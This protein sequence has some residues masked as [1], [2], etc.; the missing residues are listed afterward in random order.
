MR[1]FKISFLPCVCRHLRIYLS[2]ALRK[3]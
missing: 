1:D 2:D 3:E